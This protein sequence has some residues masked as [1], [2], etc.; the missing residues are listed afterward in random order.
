M[1]RYVISYLR[2]DWVKGEQVH[3]YHF[4][5]V[6]YAQDPHG[7]ALPPQNRKKETVYYDIPGEIPSK[8]PFIVIGNNLYR[9]LTTKEL[10]DLENTRNIER[11]EQ[12][13]LSPEYVEEE[14]GEGDSQVSK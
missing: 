14:T 11:L 2:S 9:R 8:T 10:E 1:R 13:L 12:G 6:P 5:P 4:V 7:F 3:V